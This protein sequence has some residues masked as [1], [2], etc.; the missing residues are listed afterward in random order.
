MGTRQPCQFPPHLPSEE[1]KKGARREVKEEVRREVKDEVRRE[2]KDEV[3]REVK[4]EGD[5][6]HIACI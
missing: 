1:M 2:V 6:A 4:K 3:R 5:E